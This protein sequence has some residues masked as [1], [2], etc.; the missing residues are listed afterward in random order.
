M[1]SR[2]DTRVLNTLHDPS[3][4]R[5]PTESAPPAAGA[6]VRAWCPR[7]AAA[8]APAPEAQERAG[9]PAESSSDSTAMKARHPDA[10]QS[11]GKVRTKEPAQ[12]HEP[13]ATAFK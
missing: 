2:L 13:V 11:F 1:S 5:H 7:S 4:V 12:K 9:S 3:N 6:D 8:A 10:E